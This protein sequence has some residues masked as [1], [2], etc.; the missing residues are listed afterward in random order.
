MTGAHEIFEPDSQPGATGA[1]NVFC[2]SSYLPYRVAA[3]R[4][5][6]V[7]QPR[8]PTS[9]KPSAAHFLHFP[10]PHPSHHETAHLCLRLSFWNLAFKI[11]PHAPSFLSPLSE[12]DHFPRG[13]ISQE[14]GR[15]I[16][17]PPTKISTLSVQ[18]ASWISG[19]VLDCLALDPPPYIANSISIEIPRLRG[20]TVASAAALLR[21]LG[22]KTTS[23]LL[24]FRKAITGLYSS[25]IIF[26]HFINLFCL[27]FRRFSD[28]FSYIKHLILP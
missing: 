18:L 24:D 28:P 2:G 8:V 7:T 1:H 27:H 11:L 5:A 3:S 20:D 22:S 12:R 25:L 17:Q 15:F 19:S 9:P 23:L 26:Q 6:L 16:N 21:T 14:L 13:S 4:E 10:T